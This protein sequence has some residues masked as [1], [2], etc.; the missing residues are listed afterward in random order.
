MKAQVNRVLVSL[1]AHAAPQRAG[2]LATTRE[3]G[4]HQAIISIPVF[5]L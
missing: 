4:Y 1:T 2:R 5:V 3:T